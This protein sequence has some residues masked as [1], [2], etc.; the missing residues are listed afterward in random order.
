MSPEL[1]LRPNS[2]E[3]PVHNVKFSDS[4]NQVSASKLPLGIFPGRCQVLN[5]TQDFFRMGYQP[6]AKTVPGNITSLQHG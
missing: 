2:M 5:S 3:E 6:W 4:P 1:A